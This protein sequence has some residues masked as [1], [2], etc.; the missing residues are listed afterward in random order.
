MV[1][2]ILRCVFGLAAGATFIAMLAFLGVWLVESCRDVAEDVCSLS[3]L[4]LF[5]CLFMITLVL[6]GVWLAWDA[7]HSQ[8]NSPTMQKAAK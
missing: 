7:I 2:F 4:S 6:G 1:E 3:F 5:F 8:V